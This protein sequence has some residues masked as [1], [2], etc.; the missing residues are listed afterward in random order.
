MI[1]GTIFL[2]VCIKTCVEA[3]EYLLTCW[4]HPLLAATP[5]HR[6]DGRRNQ[7]AVRLVASGKWDQ[8]PRKTAD[9]VEPNHFQDALPSTVGY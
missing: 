8:S 4:F 3:L 9:W 7:L 2:A 1:V 6:A 5:N